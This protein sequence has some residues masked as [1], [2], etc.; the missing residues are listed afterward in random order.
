M[1]TAIMKIVGVVFMAAF[2]MGRDKFLSY[3]PR[4]CS[5]T[6]E[7]PVM[8]PFIMGPSQEYQEPSTPVFVHFFT[9]G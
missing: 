4:L 8:G 9:P 1:A 5:L 6:P 2:T 7:A 3:G